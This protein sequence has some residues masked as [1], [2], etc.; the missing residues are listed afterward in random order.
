M[1]K[2][3]NRPTVCGSARRLRTSAVPSLL[4]KTPVTPQSRMVLYC[5]CYHGAWQLALGGLE[6]PP[7]IP[8]QLPN[9]ETLESGPSIEPCIEMV[10]DSASLPGLTCTDEQIP[11]H[12]DPRLYARVRGRCLARCRVG[13][14]C[15]LVLLT[16]GPTRT[17]ENTGGRRRIPPGPGGRAN[18]DPRSPPS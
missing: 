10:L 18:L 7:G 5:R 4:S 3:A 8:R 17:A 15:T 12:L 16:R 11:T 14:T 1:D 9:R 13:H 6:R 2:P